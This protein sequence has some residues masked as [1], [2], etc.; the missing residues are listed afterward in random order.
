M[1]I[2]VGTTSSAFSTS[3]A[4]IDSWLSAL[5]TRRMASETIHGI[6]TRWKKRR[7]LAKKKPKLSDSTALND[8]LTT[9]TI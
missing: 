9:G 7:R 1:N 2:T 6:V 8:S 4:S 5:P 3:T